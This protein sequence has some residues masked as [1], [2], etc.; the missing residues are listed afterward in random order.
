[1]APIS[2]ALQQSTKNL[3]QYKKVKILGVQQ[4]PLYSPEG[5]PIPLKILFFIAVC[6][7]PQ[8]LP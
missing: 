2:T 3:N 8:L 1:M 5:N 4:N 6:C 7:L